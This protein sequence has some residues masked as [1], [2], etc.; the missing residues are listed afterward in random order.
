MVEV[1]ACLLIVLADPDVFFSGNYYL[2]LCLNFSIDKTLFNFH[3]I[4]TIKLN[5]RGEGGLEVKNAL[6]NLFPTFEG[7][8]FEGIPKVRKF[9]KVLAGTDGCWSCENQF[10]EAVQ[11]GAKVVSKFL[12]QAFSIS[13]SL[14]WRV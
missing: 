10:W 8:F 13:G 12:L 7:L 9:V 1:N 4:K 5:W 11:G 14:K 6:P 3:Q 2:P